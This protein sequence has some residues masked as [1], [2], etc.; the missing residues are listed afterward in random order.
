M[1]FFRIYEDFLSE[2]QNFKGSFEE[3][4]QIRHDGAE[5]IANA[6]KE[7]GGAALLT[8]QHFKVKLPYYKNAAKGKFNVED[9]KKEL[10]TNIMKLKEKASDNVS[11]TQTDFQ[12]TVG[13]IEVLGELIIF[14]HSK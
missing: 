1:D 5:K 9:A 13:I 10:D 2:S 14:K 12:K 6:A 3:F 7:K 8:Y 4:A 11:F